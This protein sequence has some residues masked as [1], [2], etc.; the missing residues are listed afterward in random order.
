MGTQVVVF[1]HDYHLAKSAFHGPEF[2]NRPD[3]SLFTLLECPALGVVG[4]NGSIWRNN[5]RLTLRQ[6]RD[7]GMGKSKLVGPLQT[8]AMILVEELKKQA[9][10][11]RPIP[12]ALTVASVNV[13]WQMVVGKQ[14]SVTDPKLKELKDLI[15]NLV[16]SVSR[17]VI[18]DL[19]PWVRY[20]IP[21]AL[22]ERLFQYDVLYKTKERFREVVSEAINEHRASIDRDNPRDLTDGYLLEMEARVADPDSTFSDKDLTF[23]IFD[24]FFN[25][26]ESMI[27]SMM[28]MF[29]YLAS[30]PAVQRKLQA[31]I[32]DVLPKGTLPTLDDRPRMPY[33]EAVLHEV[34]RKSSL[35]SKSLQ[36][37]AVRDTRL[38]GFLIP[39]GTIL[40]A[41][42]FAMHHDPRYWDRP[43]EFLPERWLDEQGNFV[44]KKE[45]FMPF[46]VG[47]RVCL[48][49]GL[50]RMQLLIFSTAV[51][52]S[53]SVSHPPGGKTD[54]SPVP[55]NP[56]GHNPKIQD[57]YI[58]IRP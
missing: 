29:Y 2:L 4:S 25:G 13:I 54:L 55:Y 35:V 42:S 24:L 33:T 38:R 16:G 41:V 18:P 53:L 28:W 52:Q 36:R 3:L 14:F 43:D 39:K 15:N 23:L 27:K 6:L 32:D 12:H 21:K 49:E 45:G 37:V 30:Y 40:T 19:F 51:F 9:G 10:K 46:G 5:R 7:L 31:E 34:L 22:A 44:S 20:L 26:S 58:T 11:P 17:L 57:V 47:K 50:S 1:L 8:Q 56:L 48:A